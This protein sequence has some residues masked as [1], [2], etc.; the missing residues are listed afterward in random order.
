MARNLKLAQAKAADDDTLPD[1]GDGGDSV[2][3]RED[4]VTFRARSN[5]LLSTLLPVCYFVTFDW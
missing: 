4:L 1:L 3:D 2:N 5:P